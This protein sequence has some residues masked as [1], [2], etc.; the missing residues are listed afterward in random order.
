MPEDKRTAI[1]YDSCMKKPYRPK[2]E[3]V[4]ELLLY[5]TTSDTQ[6]YIDHLKHK[7]TENTVLKHA[8]Y[9]METFLK[10]ITVL[11]FL[12]IH[13]SFYSEIREYN[14]N[15]DC[16]STDCYT[17]TKNW[18]HHMVEMDLCKQYA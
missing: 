3:D 18:L 7:P 17:S 10:E 6:S 5:K 14:M 12:S 15:I 4:V 9:T 2:G 11:E 8:K 16:G 13:E 1:I